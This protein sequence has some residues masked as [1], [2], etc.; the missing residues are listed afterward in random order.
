[1]D[2]YIIVFIW[3]TDKKVV[4][5]CKGMFQIHW[6]WQ[7]Q[8]I[9]NKYLAQ[10]VHIWDYRLASPSRGDR[11]V[12]VVEVIWMLLNQHHLKLSGRPL[13][14]KV[15][16]QKSPQKT[17][18]SVKTNLYPLVLIQGPLTSDEQNGNSCD[19]SK[20]TTKQSAGLNFLWFKFL[21]CSVFSH[22]F[23]IN[24]GTLPVLISA[25][26]THKIRM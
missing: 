5:L 21:C 15:S 2:Y 23:F 1:M 6:T 12:V 11:V 9:D 4:H 8:Y 19:E 3:S 10:R 24:W 18:P 26:T 16:L 20:N 7:P 25:R 17:R 14:L 13:G 22:Y